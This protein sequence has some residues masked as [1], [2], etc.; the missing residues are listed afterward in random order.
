MPSSNSACTSYTSF[1]F[2]KD[3]DRYVQPLAALRLSWKT[4]GSCTV[5][6]FSQESGSYPTVE[7][8]T[9]TLRCSLPCSYKASLDHNQARRP[10]LGEEPDDQRRYR[11]S[12]V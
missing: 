9:T 1:R 8:Y 4:S 7:V 12:D 6:F 3:M 5:P 11:P 2:R 10:E